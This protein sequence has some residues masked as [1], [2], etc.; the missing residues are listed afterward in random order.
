MED[1]VITQ[2]TELYEDAMF[3]L[4]RESGLNLGKQGK[5]WGSWYGRVRKALPK[6]GKSSDE[7][8]LIQSNSPDAWGRLF[9]RK[10]L[11]KRKNTGAKEVLE[12]AR[13]DDDLAVRKFAVEAL[14]EDG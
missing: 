10:Q 14:K 9:E 6:F 3:L 13:T 4:R 7:E 8:I 1:K 5:N 11:L 12:K 2:H